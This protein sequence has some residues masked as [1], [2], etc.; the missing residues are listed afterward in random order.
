[1]T[2]LVDPAIVPATEAER[3]AAIQRYDILDTPPDGAFDRITALAARLFSVPIAIVSIVDH[4]RIWFKSHHGLELDQ[5][6]R[7]AGLCASAILQT[8]PWVVDN[9][10][11]D[12]RALANPLVAGEF[13]L[14]F[15]AA[16]PLRT[17]DGHNLGTMC[18]LDFEPRQLTPDETATLQDLAAMV[19][20]ELELRLASR[21]ALAR[22]EERELLKDAFVGMLSHELRTPIT[23]IYAAAHL[24]EDN[25]AIKADPRASELF[26]DIAWEAE[27]LLRLTEDLLV[28]TRVEQ[29]QL[30]ATEEPVL[31]QRVLPQAITVAGRRWPGRVIQLEIAPDLPPAAGDPVFI[32]QVMTN[33]L[34]NALKYSD[35]GAPVAVIAGRS[36]D[37]VEVRV[38]D[39]GI[40]L[41][42]DELESV[43]GLLVRTDA[44]T[45]HAPGAGIGLYVCRRL[46]EAMGGRIWAEPAPDKGS[47]FAFRLPTS[48][49]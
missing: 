35:P 24:L 27:H 38:R 40:G 11:L 41:A 3:L 20:S 28:L 13:G 15:Y 32:E 2:L 36:G 18:I 47:E 25:Q 19:M 46:L 14:R 4:D 6:D 26:P 1:M 43:F 37:E 48:T 23:T 10:P 34:S 7:V 12:P 17:V 9:A 22:A 33:L 21:S 39:Q 45:R 8:T 16:A 49:E 5:I 42:S 30:V 29:G 44:A 31:L